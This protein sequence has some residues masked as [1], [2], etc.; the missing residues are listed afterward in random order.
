[1]EAGRIMGRALQAL[2]GRGG[3]GALSLE[4]LERWMNFGW[5]GRV[6]VG[7]G[8]GMGWLDLAC[9]LGIGETCLSSRG[10]VVVRPEKHMGW[11]VRNI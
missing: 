11:N 4:E 6:C 7:G 9:L 8:R 2:W 10:I 1:M 3:G 5:A